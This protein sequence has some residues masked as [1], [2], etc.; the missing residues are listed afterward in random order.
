MVDASC[1]QQPTVKSI[2]ETRMAIAGQRQAKKTTREKWQEQQK[3]EREKCE[4][5]K[6]ALNNSQTEYINFD[7][8][9]K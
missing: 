7:G 1:V 2:H 4:M 5:Q 8:R 3:K 6:I 9:N